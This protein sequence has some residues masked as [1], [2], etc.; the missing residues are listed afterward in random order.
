MSDL[1]SHSG[2][3]SGQFVRK[4]YF[5][6]KSMEK[7]FHYHVSGFFTIFYYYLL[8]Y[9]FCLFYIHSTSTIRLQ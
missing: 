3:E 7:Y 5:A 2:P 9:I 4:L 8:L 6:Q 1:T